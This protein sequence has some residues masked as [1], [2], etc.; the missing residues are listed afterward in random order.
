MPDDLGDVRLHFVDSLDKALELKRWLGERRDVLGVDTETGGLD[1]WRCDLRTVQIGDHNTGW[2]IP[3]PDWGGL[4]K[5][6]AAEYEGDWTAHNTKFDLHFMET[7]GVFWKRRRAHDTRVMAH[8]LEPRK[9]TGLKPLSARYI[10][11]RATAG[12]F[13]LKSAMRD[14]GWG[15][16]N[17]PRDFG[18]YWQYAALD[19]VLTSRLWSKMKPQVEA[20]GLSQV[21][22]LEMAVLM[23]L[24]D[25]ERRGARIDREYCAD[26]EKQLTPWLDQMRDWI[27]LEF[28]ISNPGSNPQVIKR[29]QSDGLT[30][31]KRTAKGNVAL[32]KE[33]LRELDHPLA[34]SI[35]LYR[36]KE[37]LLNTYIANFLELSD[38]TGFL[39][40]SVNA[41]G[42]R[43]GRMSISRPSM[44]NLPRS[45]HPRN[46]IYA[47]E[48]NTLVLMD[49]DQV[50]L[51]LMAHFAD[52]TKM[53]EA[54][55]AGVDLHSWTAQLV[56]GLGDAPPSKQQRQVSK[57]SGFAKI[58]GAGFEQFSKTAGIPPH[59]G[60]AFLQRYDATFPGVRAFQDLVANVAMQRYR[61]TGTPY[62]QTPVGRMHRCD[63]DELYKLTNYLIQ[64]CL[65]PWTRVLTRDGWQP[66]IEFTDGQE[67]WTG[68]RWATA[69]LIARGPA[70]LVRVH[71]EDGRVY[72]CDERHKLLGD[73][74][75]AWPGWRDVLDL[76]S[77][78]ILVADRADNDDWGR[79]LYDVEDW[80]WFG[81]F[82]GDGHLSPRNG[83]WGMAFGPDEAADVERF[84]MWL[85]AKDVR[86]KT[87]S[88]CGYGLT[89]HRNGYVCAVTGGTGAGRALWQSFGFEIGQKAATKRIPSVVFTLDRARRQAVY[90]GYYAAD[91]KKKAGAGRS[92]F[93]RY[94]ASVNRDLLEDALK[95]FTT[96][97]GHGVI[98]ETCMRGK[99]YYEMHEWKTRHEVRVSRIELTEHVE[100]MFTLSVDDERHA[101]SSEGLISKNTAADLLKQ[102]IVALDNA[103]L[104]DYLILP[105]H[106]ELIHDIPRED[107]EAFV[108]EA[109][110]VM[111]EHEMFKVPISAGVDVYDRWGTKYLRDN[112]EVWTPPD[113]A[114]EEDRYTS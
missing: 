7:N 112:E 35:L 77:G 26:V 52:E 88:A 44:Q 20:E 111:E 108:P 107:V 103:G 48:G 57:N 69:T 99:A 53:I 2:T 23:V 83:V 40:A 49:Y 61:E 29:L 85:D 38:Q 71:L 106:D 114:E 25:M 94:I 19:P 73:T 14:Q 76:S 41:L 31:D 75:S 72:E 36:D 39:H 65:P 105:V 30:W 51:R 87:N 12:E 54:I 90:D 91:G 104:A 47:R 109:Q 62:V 59:E 89:T 79:A 13:M 3:F 33:V 55:H 24:T 86:G 81:R 4:V 15:W 96:I 43:T 68:E 58:Y 60:K 102:K 82:L 21:Y 98:R 95:L 17:I 11:P 80:Y 92:T 8:A 84:T 101:Y 16:H 22:D 10:H 27:K 28:G 6:I 63:T 45:Q 67:V 46:A 70:R 66:I 42:A 74:G 9:A 5:E 93:G 32:D 100:D 113:I 56:Y 34:K 1:W 78:D 64:G 18:P 50:E 37:K 110:R 97:G